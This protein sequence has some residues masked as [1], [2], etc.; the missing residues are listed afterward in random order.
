MYKG[1]R[2]WNNIEKNK[3]KA[4]QHFSIYFKDN[5]KVK[6]R[7]NQNAVLDFNN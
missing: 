1:K 6:Y 3:I 4:V 5:Y 7:V 2:I